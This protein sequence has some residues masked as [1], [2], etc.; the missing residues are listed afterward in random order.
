M[1]NFSRAENDTPL[2]GLGDPERWGG[3]AAV[4]VQV[5]SAP[6]TY[7]GIGPQIV[8]VQA[9]DLLARAWQIASAFE[10]RTVES[11]AEVY[12]YLRLAWGAGQASTIRDLDLVSMARSLPLFNLDLDGYGN[13]VNGA[14]LSQVP[15]P[16]SALALTPV[17]RVKALD[18]GHPYTLECR[19]S[20]YVAPWSLS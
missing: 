11:D 19:I 10:C 8:R 5:G 2:P 12:Y 7:V 9:P 4:S 13:I 1:R 18:T 3:T 16:A 15:I 14:C 20:A 17:V 6:G